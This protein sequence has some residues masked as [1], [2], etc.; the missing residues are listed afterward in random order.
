MVQQIVVALLVLLAAG[1]TVWTLAGA[2]LQRHLL[3][4]L[5]QALPVL[6]TPLGSLQRRLEAP[7]GCSACRPQRR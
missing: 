2:G 5:L 1:Y 6:R 4:V 3:R 7:A